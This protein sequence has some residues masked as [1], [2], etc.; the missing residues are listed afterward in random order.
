MRIRVARKRV[1]AGRAPAM[2]LLLAVGAG[3]CDARG[4][5]SGPVPTAPAP[6]PAPPP[7]SRTSTASAG[8]TVRA[9]VGTMRPAGPAIVRLGVDRPGGETARN[10]DPAHGPTGSERRP[11][12]GIARERETRA[13]SAAIANVGAGT[14][15]AGPL[16]GCDNSLIYRVLLHGAKVSVSL[17]L[18]LGSQARIAKS[19]HITCTSRL[20]GRLFL[21][22]R[23]VVGR[24]T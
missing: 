23:L 13:C 8:A 12:A 14:W 7:P 9:S 21:W 22:N 15:P 2:G 10:T 18:S 17:S 16:L 20:S 4:D 24:G 3:G 6:P 5:A 19:R 1:R 11:R